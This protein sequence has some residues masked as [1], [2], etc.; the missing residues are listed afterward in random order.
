MRELKT[1]RFNIKKQTGLAKRIAR[2]SV[3]HNFSKAEQFSRWY[4]DI[5]EAL[6]GALSWMT[7][8][9]GIIPLGG[10]EVTCRSAME[11]TAVGG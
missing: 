5:C 11:G 10:A 4:R 1:N 7:G 9:N 2:Q 6:S 3:C 8:R